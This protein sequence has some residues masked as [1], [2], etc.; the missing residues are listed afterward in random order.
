MTQWQWHCNGL[1]HTLVKVPQKNKTLKKQ[2]TSGGNTGKQGDT[3]ASCMIANEGGVYE[4]ISKQ[5]NVIVPYA[6]GWYL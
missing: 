5:C 2:S 3:K 4:V 1:C 6:L